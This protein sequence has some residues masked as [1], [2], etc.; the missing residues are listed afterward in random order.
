MYSLSIPPRKRYIGN[1]GGSR[2]AGT[3]LKKVGQ[4]RLV[5]ATQLKYRVRTASGEK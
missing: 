4:S 2:E 5:T 3:A 1:D